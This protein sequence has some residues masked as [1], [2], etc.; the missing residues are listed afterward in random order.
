[1]QQ[2]VEETNRLSAEELQSVLLAAAKQLPLTVTRTF[3]NG[4]YGYCPVCDNL[5]IIDNKYCSNCGQKVVF[6][7]RK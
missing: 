1:M 7:K 6:Q 3:R 2:Q 4:W 5:L